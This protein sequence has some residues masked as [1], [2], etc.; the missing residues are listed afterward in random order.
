M[1][2]INDTLI[3]IQERLAGGQSAEYIANW[4][5]IPIDWVSQVENEMYGHWSEYS[6]SVSGP[7]WSPHEGP[8]YGPT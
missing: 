1:G 3:D 5:E 2:R 7:D 4:L 6:R 8:D